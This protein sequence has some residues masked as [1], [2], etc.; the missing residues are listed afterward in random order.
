MGIEPENAAWH[1]DTESI[2]PFAITNYAGTLL[3]S[4]QWSSDDLDIDSPYS[5][6]TLVNVKQGTT[7]SKDTII[8]TAVS[9]LDDSTYINNRTFIRKCTKQNFGIENATRNF[10]P[11]LEEI[12]TFQLNIYGCP[13]FHE[14]GWLEGEIMRLATD[15]WQH[16]GWIDMAP[17]IEDHQ[18]RIYVSSLQHTVVWDGI[19][20]E[21][22]ALVESPDIFAGPRGSFN[23]ALPE[24]ISDEPVPPPYYTVFFRY[25]KD[26]NDTAEI[27]DEASTTVYVPQIVNL[28]PFSG[29][30]VF[31]KPVLSEGANLNDRVVLY[32]GCT[33][34]EADA[35][36]ALLPGMVQAFFPD[37]VNIR[38]VMKDKVKGR[39]KG[40]LIVGESARDN[41]RGDSW[42]FN[43]RNER[44]SG[45]MAVYIGNLGESLK[46][47]Y[48]G[49][50]AGNKDSIPVPMTPEQFAQHIAATIAHEIGHNVGLVDPDY[51]EAIKDGRQKHHNKVRTWNKIMDVGGLFYVG[52]R[53]NPHP[54]GY[55]LPN[56]LRYLRF[57]LPTGD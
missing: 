18:K 2:G 39:H 41:L 48:R 25:R 19:A 28:V 29:M 23:R 22:A 53:L 16:V 6:M 42:G 50:L 56:N 46:R 12:A 13:H 47:N 4:V 24:V 11:H 34:E 15:G 17:D 35:A 40:V 36:L 31:Q 8:L 49:M 5:H 1:F 45:E 38:I 21:N 20:T 7:L 26:N 55:W 32:P 44:V 57:I 33:E 3:Y 43:K 27:L 37:D 54:T 9:E 52:H 10:S 30:N 14:E 51:L